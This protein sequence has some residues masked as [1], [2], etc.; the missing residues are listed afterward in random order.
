M[1]V[2]TTDRQRIRGEALAAYLMAEAAAQYALRVG[3]SIRLN[4]GHPNAEALSHA[5]NALCRGGIRA[6]RWMERAIKRMGDGAKPD[7]EALERGEQEIAALAHL[8]LE[9][10]SN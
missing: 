4:A 10:P 3:E 2:D 9:G 6:R 5:M 7:T 8:H 1:E